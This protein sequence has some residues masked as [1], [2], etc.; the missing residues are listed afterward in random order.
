MKGIIKEIIIMLL[1]L[2]AIILA[3]GVLL[4][5]YIPI[6]KVVPTIEEY[7]VSEQVQESLK[8][9][10]LADTSKVIV[11]KEIDSSDLSLYEKTK[12]YSKGKAN[13]FEVTS[14]TTTTSTT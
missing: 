3:L 10:I 11:T 4:Y 2:L 6:S 12:D 1:L 14:S 7:K 8:N 13:P 9:D 5:N